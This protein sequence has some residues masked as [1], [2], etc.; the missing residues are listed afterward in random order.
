MSLDDVWE[1]VMPEP[2][3][4]RDRL[5]LVRPVAA[6]REVAD[7]EY[8]TAYLQFFQVRIPE[9]LHIRLSQWAEQEQKTLDVLLIEILEQAVSTRYETLGT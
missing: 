6:R 5:D 9:R 4:N 2:Q 3:V 1:D 7:W 8:R